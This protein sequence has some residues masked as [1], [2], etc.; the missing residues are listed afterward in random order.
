M[1][2]PRGP[3]SLS[4]NHEHWAREWKG[5]CNADSWDYHAHALVEAGY[6]TISYDKRGFGRSSQPASG[7]DFDTL[8]ADLAAVID[9][10]DVREATLVGYSMGG[11]EIVRYLSRYGRGESPRSR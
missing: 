3:H 7:Y 10:S 9:A 6:R 11:G 5:P 4:H 8:A 1:R 2:Q